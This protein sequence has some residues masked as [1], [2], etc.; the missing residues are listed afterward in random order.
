MYAT[1]VTTAPYR[2]HLNSLRNP[3]KTTR[4]TAPHGYRERWANSCTHTFARRETRS[5]NPSAGDRPPVPAVIAWVDARLNAGSCLGFVVDYASESSRLLYPT[6]MNLL[7]PR[8]NSS[9]VVV[10]SRPTNRRNRVFSV[11][12]G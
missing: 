8:V 2:N 6:P 11:Q 9:E 7:V 12:C 4:L 5:R 1:L 10:C 3:P